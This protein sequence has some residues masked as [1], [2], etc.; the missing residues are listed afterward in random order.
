MIYTNDYDA[1]T[2]IKSDGCMHA[3]MSIKFVSLLLQREE[4]E[5]N[6]IKKKNPEVKLTALISLTCR[7][8]EYWA[9]TEITIEASLFKFELYRIC[10][11]MGSQID[12]KIVSAGGEES[13]MK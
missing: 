2:S 11:K 9:S 3:C 4:T 13:L 8:Q 10:S 6:K 1:H 7:L 12:R 5:E